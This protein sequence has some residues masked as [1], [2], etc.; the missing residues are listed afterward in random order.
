[1]EKRASRVPAAGPILP[2]GVGCVS[3]GRGQGCQPPTPSWHSSFHDFQGLFRKGGHDLTPAWLSR[4]ERSPGDFPFWLA[5][6]EITLKLPGRPLNRPVIR[7]LKS[8]RND[9]S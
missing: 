7:R 1:M 4:S 3:F 9:N 6:D 8:S 2:G 5:I